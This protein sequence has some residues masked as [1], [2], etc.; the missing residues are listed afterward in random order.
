MV[1][2]HFR[3]FIEDQTR[4]VYPFLRRVT[5]VLPVPRFSKLTLMLPFMGNRYS[6]LRNTLEPINPLPQAVSS[7]EVRTIP[8]LTLPLEAFRKREYFLTSQ[9]ALCAVAKVPVEFDLI[10]AHF[11]TFGYTAAKLKEKYGKPF[12]LTAHGGD[13]YSLPFTNDW[14]NRLAKQIV[15]KADCIITVSSHNMKKLALLG[16]PSS[17]MHLIPNGYDEKIF[18]PISKEKVRQILG[19]PLNKKILLSVGNLLP[20]KGHTYLL[21]AVSLISKKCDDVILVIVGSGPLAGMLEKKIDTLHLRNRVFLVGSKSHGEIPLWMNACDLFVLPSLNEGFATVIPE[22][23]ACGKPVV[24]TRVGGGPDAISN[25][26]LGIL[27]DPKNS[28]KLADAITSAL[29][30]QWSSTAIM[31][32]AKKYR[33]NNIAKQILSVYKRALS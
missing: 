14:Y 28:V 2:P 32:Y 31:D 29:E 19:L 11:L 33:W 8:Y 20:V 4:S 9:S 7:V 25:D 27:V 30:H 16:V 12:V 15:S 17:R 21:D 6:F 3:F 24:A 23:M 26:E 13:V 5:A 1:A 18:R 10:H 22:A